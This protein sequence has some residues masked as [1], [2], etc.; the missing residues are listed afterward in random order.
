MSLAGDD[1]KGK[2]ALCGAANVVSLEERIE[3]DHAIA[4]A[5]HF[6]DRFAEEAAGRMS[7]EIHIYP[8]EKDIE[9]ERA[10]RVSEEVLEQARKLGVEGDVE[11]QVRRMARDAT[12]YTHPKA[13][14]RHGRFALKIEGNTVTW[15]GLVDEPGGGD[16]K[17]R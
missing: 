5:R 13:G 6:L 14:L 8:P 16:K 3:V 10:Y 2:S 17:S 4:V 11:Q 9:D 7:L 1:G 12:P 15:I